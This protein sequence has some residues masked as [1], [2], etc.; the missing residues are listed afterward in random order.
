L[1]EA[2]QLAN[3]SGGG[4]ATTVVSQGWPTLVEAIQKAGGLTAQ[5][6]LRRVTLLR[7][8]GTSGRTE[9]IQ[10]NYW[11]ALRSG[12]PIS[13]PL[14]YDGDS[15]RIPL[16]EQQSKSEL[17]TIASSSFAPTSIT[18]NV[19]GEVERPGPQQVRANSPLSFAV[20]A[21]GGVS[22][23]GN[24]NTLELFR[25]QSN[26]TME[27]QQLSYRPGEAMGDSNN[28][29][30]RNGDVVVVDRH[31]WAKST[32]GLKAALEPIGSLVGAASIFALLGVGF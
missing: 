24:N 10:V 6:D 8:V 18:V 31:S 9:S 2:N 32:D 12:A 26:G 29:P 7:P 19:V 1:Q 21:A 16:A 15:I 3:S 28:P 20:Q 14:I 22:R 27:R 4:Q 13:N 11:E 23:R 17:L 5:G 30:L 25:L